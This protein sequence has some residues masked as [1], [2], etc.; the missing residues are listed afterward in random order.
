MRIYLARLIDDIAV[1]DL[2][3]VVIWKM[4]KSQFWNLGHTEQCLKKK[5]S[6]A[7]NLLKQNKI[8]IIIM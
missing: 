8:E 7:T 2:C 5:K 3:Y 6:L 1:R 4:F